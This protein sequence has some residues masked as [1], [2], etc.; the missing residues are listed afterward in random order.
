MPVKVRGIYWKT[1][2][3]TAVFSAV[4]VALYFPVTRGMGR[5]IN[6]KPD[7]SYAIIWQMWWFKRALLDL[8]TSPFF[9]HFVESP[10][11]VSLTYTTIVNYIVSLPFTWIFGPV[12]SYNI[13][14]LFSF[15]LSGVA[16][17]LL[18]L[19]LTSHQAASVFSGLLYAFSPYHTVFSA[20]GGMDAA[21]IQYMPLT[22]LFV[23]RHGRSGSTLDLAAAFCFFA[24]ALLSFGYYGVITSMMLVIYWAHRFAF[25]RKYALAERSGGV[26]FKGGEMIKTAALAVS[27]YFFIVLL[28]NALVE[29]SVPVRVLAL[30][31]A[32]LGLVA[33]ITPDGG[34]FPEFIKDAVNSYRRRCGGLVLAGAAMTFVLAAVFLFPVYTQASRSISESYFTPFYSF[35]VPAPDHPILGTLIPKGVIPGPDPFVGK[36]VYIGVTVT[37]LALYSL[38]RRTG[39]QEKSYFTLLFFAGLLLMLRPV[40]RIGDFSLYGPIYYFHKIVP[41]FVDVRRMV[42]LVLISACVLA[43]YAVKDVFSS[44]KSGVFRTAFYIIVISAAAI[45]FYPSVDAHDLNALPNEY[46]WL[47]QR[48]G[49]FNVVI[50]PLTSIYDSKRYEAFY[51]QTLHGKGIVNPFGATGHVPRPSSETLRPLMD[52]GGPLTEPFANPVNAAGVL[53]YLGIKYAVVRTEAMRPAGLDAEAFK[54][55]LPGSALGVYE[56]VSEKRPYYLSFADFYSAGYFANYLEKKDGAYVQ[57]NPYVQPAMSWDKDGAWLWMGRRASMVIKTLDGR[58]RGYSVRFSAKSAAGETVLKAKVNGVS[59]A[60]LTVGPEAKD[61]VLSGITSNPGE[62]EVKIDL[63]AA[64][65]LTTATG[66]GPGDGKGATQLISVAVRKAVVK[67]MGPAG[68]GGA[69][70]TGAR[71]K[72]PG[73]FEGIYIKDGST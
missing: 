2:L 30:A 56:V 33:V 8:H 44:I 69:V 15:V 49:D 72:K 37:A 58:P 45:E 26:S 17:Y 32:P 24:L 27:A 12:F 31:A 39:G 64:G 19:E 57:R 52:T 3:S 41:Q 47:A 60:E 59:F 48:P 34:S 28:D 13:M 63:E 71:L 68:T 61:F 70:D 51:G 38:A 14:V 73:E 65:E 36:M 9:T 35:F 40:V 29:A 16:M 10:F 54:E 20:A 23:I 55:V 18:T 6:G 53:S 43:G 66:L 11:G 22:M 5:Y 21:Q 67:E 50:Y 46:G 62:A 42:L 7:D 25:R 1:I 4:T